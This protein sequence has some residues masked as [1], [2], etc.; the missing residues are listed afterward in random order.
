MGQSLAL[1]DSCASR[2][3]AGAPYR[4]PGC[5]AGLRAPVHTACW[6]PDRSGAA[7]R[8]TRLRRRFRAGATHRVRPTGT[9]RCAPPRPRRRRHRRTAQT[10]S[11]AAPR[12]GD[13]TTGS[14]YRRGGCILARPCPTRCHAPAGRDAPRPSASSTTSGHH[15][16]QRPHRRPVSRRGTTPSGVGVAPRHLVHRSGPHAVTGACWQVSVN[17]GWRHADR[18]ELT[19]AAVQPEVEG[20]AVA[21]PCSRLR[22]PG[23]GPWG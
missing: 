21:S 20:E 11:P 6:A 2:P 7:G 22:S 5:A 13:P 3:T 18:L 10:D 12:R 1:R 23:R 8:S 14:G 17:V 9:G 15:P 4:G 19:T 16:R